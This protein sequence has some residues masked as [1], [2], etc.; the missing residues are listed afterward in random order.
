[1]GTQSAYTPLRIAS[2]ARRLM[3][4]GIM[5]TEPV[6]YQPVLNTP[7]TTDYSR[8]PSQPHQ[9]RPRNRPSDIRKIQT[10]Q[11]GWEVHF[12]RKFYKQHPWELARP[13]VVVEEDGAD[14]IRL[15]WSKLEQIGKPLDGERFLCLRFVLSLVLCNGLCI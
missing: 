2:Q 5:R 3:E 11:K 14:Y 9:G 13:K 6:W 7:P 1:M 4:Q 10:I 15:D 12:R 8:K